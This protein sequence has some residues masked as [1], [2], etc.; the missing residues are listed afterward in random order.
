MKCCASF[1]N[2]LVYKVLDTLLLLLL[3]AA[4]TI[5]IV[6]D[7]MAIRVNNFI[8]SSCEVLSGL[9]IASSNDEPYQK[10]DL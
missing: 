9:P 8:I 4:G 6:H 1:K 7:L 2:A 10:A 5:F 3:A